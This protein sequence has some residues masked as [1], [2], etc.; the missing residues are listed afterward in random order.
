ML[1]I[2]EDA[3]A[4][5]FGHPGDVRH[6]FIVNFNEVFEEAAKKDVFLSN[7]RKKFVEF[8]LPES[9]QEICI[10]MI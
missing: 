10:A 3:P 1:S 6:W 9:V 8:P 4:D 2:E 7:E 5:F